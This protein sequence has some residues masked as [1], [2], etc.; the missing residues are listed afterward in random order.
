MKPSIILVREW[1]QQMSSSGCCG[2]L[3]GD[4]LEL[5]K[6]R[7]FPRRRQIMEDMGPLYRTIRNHYGDSV[8]L[9]VIDPR[10][11]VVLFF[12]LARDFFRYRVGFPQA[13]RTLRG[14]SIVTVIVNGRLFARETWP[15][16]EALSAHVDDLMH[17][18]DTRHATLRS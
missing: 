4:L 6:E 15:D 12:C 9:L 13:L 5:G 10:N 2:R 14:L 17:E 18:E 11:Q 16:P 1:Q 3:E 8:E 7:I